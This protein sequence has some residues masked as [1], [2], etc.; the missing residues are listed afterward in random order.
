MTQKIDYRAR[1]RG[2][3]S[4]VAE[5]TRSLITAQVDLGIARD[6]HTRSSASLTICEGDLRAARADAEA[7]GKRID[8][9]MGELATSKYRE[10]SFKEM[11][12]IRG[13][14]VVT[15]DAQLDRAL[16]LGLDLA[17][18]IPPAAPVSLDK[19]AS[20]AY[21]VRRGYVMPYKKAVR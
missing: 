15:L 14:R 13:E 19:P 17:A 1:S 18:L 6:N 3:A 20:E 7:F 4:Q 10:E 12:R 11:A 8:A 16:I 9:L 21:I 2:L 5:L